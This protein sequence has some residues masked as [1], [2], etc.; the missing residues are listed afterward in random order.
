MFIKAEFLNNKPLLV[1]GCG[2]SP[3]SCS[4]MHPPKAAITLDAD[5]LMKPDY[6]VEFPTKSLPNEIESK[7][8]KAIIFEYFPMYCHISTLQTLKDLLDDDGVVVLVGYNLYDIE[9][10]KDSKGFYYNSGES[11]ILFSKSQEITDLTLSIKNCP[12]LNAYL[13]SCGID[14]SVQPTAIDLTEK[15][16]FFIPPNALRGAVLYSIHF[17]SLIHSLIYYKDNSP[18][19]FV[20]TICSINKAIA[21]NGV[22]PL[23]RKELSKYIMSYKPG[24]FRSY[25]GD[26][27]TKGIAD[28]TTFN[29]VY[30][31]ENAPLN[32]E[33]R[34]RLYNIINLHQSRMIG[35]LNPTRSETGETTRVIMSIL[36]HL[37]KTETAFSDGLRIR[38][39]VF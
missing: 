26:G 23:T 27:C 29:A 8:F 21:E 2:H 22:A 9:L 38:G 34:A 5:P 6:I 33:E 28:L 18:Q 20:D 10:I 1:I 25:F 13:S 12:H 32:E 37:L 19:S 39:Q 16:Y 24:F 30:A 15:S 36:E 17:D 3:R 4:K 31:D 7:K 35:S 11:H 14:T